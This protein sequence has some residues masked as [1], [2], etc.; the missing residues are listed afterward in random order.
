MYDKLDPN[1]LSLQLKNTGKKIYGLETEYACPLIVRIYTDVNENLDKEFFKSCVEK[2][3]VEIPVE[4]AENKKI[5]LNYKFIGMEPQTTV[6]SRRQ[7]LESQLPDFEMVY[8]TNEITSQPDNRAIYQ[9]IYPA[10]CKTK[11]KNSIP[12]LSRY[13]STISGIVGIKTALTENN[14]FAFQITYNKSV[15]DES[16]LW[17]AVSAA[18]WVIVLDDNSKKEID[19]RISFKKEGKTL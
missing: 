11:V 13:L 5:D 8:E 17:K 18:K 1:Y 12:L 7:L 6:I 14:E 15:I 2:E 9:I 10:L 3:Y 16:T 19:A 4:G